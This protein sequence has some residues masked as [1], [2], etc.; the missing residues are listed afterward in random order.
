MSYRIARKLGGEMAL[1]NCLVF[2]LAKLVDAY[3]RA[4]LRGCIGEYLIWQ[5][6]H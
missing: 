3:K 4:W 2:Y 6:S 5:S 1:L